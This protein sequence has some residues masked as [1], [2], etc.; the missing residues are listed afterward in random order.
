MKTIKHLR[1]INNKLIYLKY[2]AYDVF[3]EHFILVSHCHDSVL[4]KSTT[5]LKKLFLPKLKAN[6]R[7]MSSL[8]KLNLTLN[9]FKDSLFYFDSAALTAALTLCCNGHR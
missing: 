9:L 1:H 8:A 6:K 3:M 5:A 7:A 4:H 2:T